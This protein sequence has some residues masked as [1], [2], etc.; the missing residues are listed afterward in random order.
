MR[1]LFA[2]LALSSLS[3]SATAATGTATT[4][5]VIDGETGWVETKDVIDGE[6]GW[7]ETKDVIDGETGW[8]E[9]KD[10]IDGETGWVETK[11]VIDGETGWVETKGLSLTSVTTGVVVDIVAANSSVWTLVM[12][13]GSVI[14]LTSNDVAALG[15]SDVYE[16]MGTTFEMQMTTTP[17]GQLQKKHRIK[18]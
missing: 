14:Q 8:V 11:D 5:D 9:T 1:L 7:V 16:L 2:F 3:L 15:V 12:D 18:R 4:H 6:T 10:V 17:Q 13:N